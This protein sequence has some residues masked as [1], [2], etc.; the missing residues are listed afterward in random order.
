ML[1][2]RILKLRASD[3][4]RIKLPI[5]RAEFEKGRPLKRLE[6]QVLRFLIEGEEKPIPLWR[7]LMS[8][9]NLE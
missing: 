9:S 4:F 8:L 6:E 1:H 5:S 2:A 7:S 3:S